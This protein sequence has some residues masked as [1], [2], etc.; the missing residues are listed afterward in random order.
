MN[1]EIHQNFPEVKGKVI[2]KVELSVESDYYGI[3]IRFQDNTALS[4]TIE[5]S[6]TVSPVYAD[7]TDGEEK[8]LKEYQPVRSMVSFETEARLKKS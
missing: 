8:I 3:S 5:P 6:V 2:E 7:W 1:P 4:F